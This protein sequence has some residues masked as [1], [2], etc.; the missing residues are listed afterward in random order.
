MGTLLTIIIFIVIFSLLVLIHEAGHFWAAKSAGIK[1]EEFGFGFGPRIIGIKKGETVYTINW[2]PFGGFVRMLGEDSH[3]KKLLKN[4]RSFIAK[5]KWQRTKV[6]VAGVVMNF[7]LAFV[8]LTFGF[9]VGI[10]PLLA[11]SDD[12]RNAINSG[13]MQL[14]SG[15]VIEEVEP[16]SKA[17]KLGFKAGDV[18]VGFLEKGVEKQEDYLEAVL[19]GKV[20]EY[21]LRR[22]KTDI[23]VDVHESLEG[24]EYYPAQYYPAVRVLD[25][26]HQWFTKNSY[27]YQ[28]FEER[29]FSLSELKSALEDPDVEEPH[30]MIWRENNESKVPF[31]GVEEV[32]Y[33]GLMIRDVAEGSAAQGAGLQV[34]DL[35]LA[36]ADQQIKTPNDLSDY[37]SQHPNEE[38]VYLA[39]T[40]ERGQVGIS[41]KTDSKGLIGV[42]VTPL[43]YVSTGLDGEILFYDDKVL[44]STISLKDVVYPWYQA[45]IEAV[46][47][48]GR[49]SLLTA[50]MFGNVVAD[51]LTG[52]GVPDS[53]AGPIGIY[54]ITDV[55]VDDGLFATLRFIALLSLSLG[56][57]NIL[58]FPALDGGRLMF[59]IFEAITG[60]KMNQKWEASIHAIGFI[61]LIL[62]ILVVTYS[63]ILRFI[64]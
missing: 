19:D 21:Q 62:L 63:D 38:L 34:G 64:L 51:L 46:K 11:S 35:I 50:S 9:I 45:P 25:S 8:L 59:I 20:G 26:N 56:V 13:D 6:V 1:V 37:T 41:I 42:S 55:V 43:L 52:G 12:V 32:A 5:S 47:E 18:V 17:E 57:I 14:Q 33:Q 23:S 2:I 54:H 31:R 61:L 60:R 40:K 15:L 28:H 29:L 16:D 4:P 39:Q 22:G 24:V 27:V 53:V 30:F 7:A 48:M 10:A 44:A 36:V 49:L 58:P 3:D